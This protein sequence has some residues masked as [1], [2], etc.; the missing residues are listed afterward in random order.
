MSALIASSENVGFSM[1]H[2]F[3]HDELN[4][5][6]NV[7]TSGNAFDFYF[8]HTTNM[9]NRRGIPKQ[10]ATW[11]IKEWMD[12][13]RIKQARMMEKTGWSKA[14]MSQIYNGVQDFNPKI[15]KEAASALN[16][17]NYELLMSPEK[18]MALRQLQASAHTIVHLAH[19]NDPKVENDVKDNNH[20][21]E[22]KRGENGR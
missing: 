4:I 13:Y 21:S 6:G 8:P 19:E 15:V 7:R 11:Y 3:A 18:A 14:S 1:N 5:K 16:L 9:A 22:V 17:Q 20:L 12:Y 10:G 2:V